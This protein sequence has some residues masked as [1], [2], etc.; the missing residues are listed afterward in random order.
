[1]TRLCCDVSSPNLAAQDAQGV[2]NVFTMPCELSNLE[3]GHFGCCLPY[4]LLCIFCSQ[5]ANLQL[6]ALLP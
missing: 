3:F 2:W 6:I 1:M 4:K 5:R